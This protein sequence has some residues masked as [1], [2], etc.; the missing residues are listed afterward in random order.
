M[1]NGHRRD[2]GLHQ[3]LEGFPCVRPDASEIEDRVGE[4]PQSAVLLKPPLTWQE[5]KIEPHDQSVPLVIVLKACLRAAFFA[6]ASSLAT[7]FTIRPA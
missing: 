7:F 5:S 4:A 3:H 6:A 2:V 1:S